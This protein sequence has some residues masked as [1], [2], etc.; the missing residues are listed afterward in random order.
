MS[1]LAN[2]AGDLVQLGAKGIAKN[3][4]TAWVAAGYIEPGKQAEMEAGLVDDVEVL[5]AMVDKGAQAQPAAAPKPG[6]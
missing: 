5:L 2:V 1:I 6:A 3:L 4:V